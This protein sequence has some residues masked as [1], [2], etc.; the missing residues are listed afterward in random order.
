MT[1]KIKLIIAGGGTAGWV[2]AA[3]MSKTFSQL[4]DITLIESETIGTVG[5][6]EATIP[7]HKGF[8]NLL[9]I[10]ED[11]FIK[12]TNATFKLG[13]SFEGWTKDTETYFHAFGQVGRSTWLAH[14]HHLWAAI[15]DETVRGSLDDYCLELQAA[16]H[17][18]FTKTQSNIDVNYAYH[19][20]AG[21]YAQFLR[22]FSEA[23]GVKRIEGVIENVKLQNETGHIESLE[24]RGGEIIEGDIFID[25]TG[26]KSLLLGQ[27]MGIGFEDWKDYL[28]T[29]RACV[30]QSEAVNDPVPYTRTIAH[31]AGWRWQIPLQTRLGNGVVFSSDYMSDEEAEKGF[32]TGKR[33]KVWHKNCL[34]IGLSSGFLEPLE[35][36]SIHLIQAAIT[37][38]AQLFPFS[39]QYEALSERYN[40]LNDAELH[41]I[42][43]FL[44]LHYY[45]NERNGQSF[46]DYHRNNNIPD[47]LK[48]RMSLFEESGLVFQ[49]GDD[50]FRNDSW[51]QVMLGQG[52]RP[53]AMHAAGQ[54][55]EPRQLRG[56]IGDLKKNIDNLV[57]EMP[58]HGDYLRRYRN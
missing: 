16:K 40:Q 55:I 58:R 18:K 32:R 6:G 31:N 25:C 22:K 8:H 50:L 53:K 45:L 30:A 27:A 49:D 28:P 29:D 2:S 17:N 41:D 35:S 13:I 39:K 34:A 15:G 51:V 56:A 43:D 38:F 21:A 47:S 20:D 33:K 57:S 5:V 26:F 42:R 1:P 7:T 52:L 3:L 19:L 36:T 14:F 54:L 4:L 9:N 23:N 44:I 48:H 10:D 24:L 11:E 12:A 37:R 46:W